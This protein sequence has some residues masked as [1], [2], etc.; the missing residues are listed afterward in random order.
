MSRTPVRTPTV[1]PASTRL[2]GGAISVVQLA[3]LRWFYNVESSLESTTI[4]QLVVALSPMP[5]SME[6]LQLRKHAAS[7]TA[8]TT[9]LASVRKVCQDEAKAWRPK[10]VVC[11]SLIFP[12][13]PQLTKRRL[14]DEA[15]REVNEHVFCI[16]HT[17]HTPH[18]DSRRFERLPSPK[19]SSEASKH[20]LEVLSMFPVMNLSG[21]LCQC[22]HQRFTMSKALPPMTAPCRPCHCQP[23]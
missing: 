4:G 6:G 13:S 3:H 1:F 16:F 9:G 23:R 5:S 19:Y 10:E 20:H 21:H 22:Y 7:K 14:T 8:S 2:T 15:M 18:L 12:N 17:N 11:C